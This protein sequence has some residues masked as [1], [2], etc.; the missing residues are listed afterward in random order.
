MIIC[1]APRCVLAEEYQN[2]D[3]QSINN[4]NLN[5]NYIEEDVYED[6]AIRPASI[7][8]TIATAMIF[9]YTYYPVLAPKIAEW[10]NSYGTHMTVPQM[11]D[12]ILKMIKEGK[13]DVTMS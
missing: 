1:N 3:T 9:F 2:Y 12:T 4:L 10:L 6:P 8:G 11:I 5:S 7:A 13:F